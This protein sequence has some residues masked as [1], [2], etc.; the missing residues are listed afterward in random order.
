MPTDDALSH[1]LATQTEDLAQEFR[2]VLSHETVAAC[3][4]DCLEQLAGARISAFVPTLAYRFAR[5]HLQ[6]M[7]RAR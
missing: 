5:E 4:A 6:E 1:R 3:L 2:G 7:A